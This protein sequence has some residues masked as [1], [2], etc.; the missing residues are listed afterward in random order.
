MRLTACTIVAATL[1]AT[2]LPAAAAWKEYRY[3]DLGVVKEFPVAPKMQTG[4]YK[5]PVAGTATAHILTAEEEGIKYTLTVV[6]LMNKV[7][8][9]ATLMGE[10]VYLAED[11]G[12]PVANM[13]ARVEPGPRAIYGRIISDDLKDGSRAM[14]ACFYTKGRLYKVQALVLPSNPD[15]PNSS[16][17]IRFVNSLSFNMRGDPAEDAATDAATRGNR[18]GAARAGGGE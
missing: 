8:Q 10:C 13:M 11:E 2:T 9:G 6:D 5:T 18:G 3:E 15:Y 7:E 12:K 17:A 16:Q 1:V 14:T 4:T